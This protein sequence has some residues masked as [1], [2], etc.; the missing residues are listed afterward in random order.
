MRPRL[1]LGIRAKLLLFN[2]AAVLAAVLLDVALQLTTYGAVREF[3]T[4]LVR[5][6]SLHRLRSG[7]SAQHARVENLMRE[8]PEEAGELALEQ[9]LQ[10]YL[11]VINQLEE[12]EP[13][14]LEVFFARQAAERGLTAYFEK[15]EAAVRRRTAGDRN[16]YQDM[17]WAGR[18]AGYIDGYLATFL[19]EAMRYGDARYQ[20]HVR[21]IELTRRFT[22]A[23]LAAFL[24]LFGAAAAAFSSS[25]AAPI[26]RLAAAS[27]RIAAGELN[28]PEVLALTGDEVEILARSFHTMS[29]SIASMVVDLKGKAELE[30]NLREEERLLMEKERALREARF[31][32]LQ[33]QIQPHFLFNALNTIAR[34][35]LLEGAPRTEAL[36]LALARLLR[37]ALGAPASMVSLRE[38][39][40]IVEEYL[41][42]QRIRFGDR[43][44]WTVDAPESVLSLAIPRFTVQ[45][46]VE[47]A[48]RHGIE[49]REEGGRVDIRASIRRGRLV[50]AIRDTGVGMDLASRRPESQR[51]MDGRGEGIGIANVRRRLELR[52]GPSARLSVR[53]RKGEGTE[54]LLRMPAES[55][56][57]RP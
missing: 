14:S 52:Y 5:Y 2:G 32:A 6:H 28:V 30:R 18:I 37:Y 22:L 24:V 41:G 10:D 17:A 55:G 9:D 21:R 40:G 7:L 23:A 34:T 46:F 42:F 33:D 54:V 3:E 47:N 51:G 36:S 39:L 57:R 19:S 27:E 56:E 16:W 49:P 31:I 25:I 15:L 43:L 29:R 45:P 44:R 12:A 48:V 13:E 1:R 11:L 35:A 38:E 4:R 50:L 53:S 8:T 20:A 26:R